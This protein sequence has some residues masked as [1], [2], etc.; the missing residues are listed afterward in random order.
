M[1]DRQEGSVPA[2]MIPDLDR[3]QKWYASDAYAPLLA[4]REVPATSA[5]VVLPGGITVRE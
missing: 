2:Y 1:L 3:A 4:L 5:V